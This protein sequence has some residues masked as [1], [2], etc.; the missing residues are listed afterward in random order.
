MVTDD[1]Q[2]SLRIVL[3]SSLVMEVLKFRV[4]PF[5]IQFN[6]IQKLKPFPLTLYS[7]F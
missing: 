3:P 7:R 4:S 6:P 2:L 5:L 1:A